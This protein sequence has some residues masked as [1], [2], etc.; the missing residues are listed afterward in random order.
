M[1]LELPDTLCN[2]LS[3]AASAQGKRVEEIVEG[4][5]R[6]YLHWNE[7]E[8]VTGEEI[9]ECQMAMVHELPYMGDWTEEQ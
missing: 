2:E 5:I 1:T 8:E 6:D 4:L 9:G 7:I 3:S